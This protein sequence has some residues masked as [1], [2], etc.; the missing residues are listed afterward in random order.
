M[1][2]AIWEAYIYIYIVTDFINALT[3]NS[4]VNTFQHATVEEAMF[5]LD[6]TDAP[7]D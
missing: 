2:E 6:L 3:G 5:S 1:E 7:I 4:S